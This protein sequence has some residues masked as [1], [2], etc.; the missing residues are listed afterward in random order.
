[1]NIKVKSKDT[2]Q[3]FLRVYST[4]NFLSP[5]L[6]PY[7]LSFITGQWG[8]FTVKNATLYLHILS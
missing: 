8:E 6:S 4:D 1:M 7:L 5:V 2:W 3:V